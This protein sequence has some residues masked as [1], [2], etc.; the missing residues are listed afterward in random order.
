MCIWLDGHWDQTNP[1]GH[2]DRTSRIDWKYDEIYGLIHQL[3]PNCLIGNNH[4]LSPIR[5]ED[6]QMFE[7]DL[8]GENKSGLSY[9]QASTEMPLES[10]ETMNGSWGFN[11][12]DNNYKSVKTVLQLLIRAA[13]YNANLLLNV[14]PMPDGTIQSEF[15][16]T[17]KKAGEWLQKNGESIYGTRG[18]LV[19]PKEWGTVTVKDNLAF[20]HIL[21][22]PGDQNYV[23]IPG[24]AKK[25]VNA[26]LYSDKTKVKFKQQA[27][28]LFIYLDGARWD[29]IDTIILLDLK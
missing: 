10:C 13:G 12:T 11:I 9:Q 2:A 26:S 23:F 3:Q 1:E 15:V 22:R 25:V 4:H 20:V 18:G 19:P 28:G 7:R 29:E 16:D 27:E 14:G 21:N 5:G 6:F 24:L 8:P 17:L